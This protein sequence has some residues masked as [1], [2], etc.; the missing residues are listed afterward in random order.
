MKTMK[1]LLESRDWF[2]NPC[3]FSI[4]PTGM[5]YGFTHSLSYKGVE[6]SDEEVEQALKEYYQFQK[7]FDAVKK[8]GQR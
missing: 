1:L 4:M 3:W 6:V 2:R 5:L 8:R 7:F